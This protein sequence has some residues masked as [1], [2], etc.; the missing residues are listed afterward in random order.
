MFSMI[1]ARITGR[2]CLVMA[3][4]MLL[5]SCSLLDWF[6]PE[7]DKKKPV[8]VVKSWNYRDQWRVE[9]DR[10]PVANVSADNAMTLSGECSFSPELTRILDNQ[11]KG[12]LLPVMRAADDLTLYPDLGASAK[13][14][15]VLDDHW[16]L[17][18]VGDS[19]QLYQSLL[20]SIEH[21]CPENMTREI[22]SCSFK[23]W[24]S[25]ASFGG[26]DSIYD[27][28]R[29]ERWFKSHKSVRYLVMGS[30]G[31]FTSKAMQS[32]R[33]SENSRVISEQ[34]DKKK[35]KYLRPYAGQV[36]YDWVAPGK[37]DDQLFKSLGY[38]QV[39]WAELDQKRRREGPGWLDTNSLYSVNK[40]LTPYFIE[41]LDKAAAQLPM[42][43]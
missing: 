41:F 43:K 35:S 6:R 37:S 1:S 7:P 40:A 14:Y 13:L 15:K 16:A 20:S 34:S 4:S 36:R 5:S 30:S 3:V 12:V 8:P 22:D 18:N 33:Y 38:C 19:L 28:S 32:A 42:K 9:V 17:A 26:S 25:F 31:L 23:K 2:L 39:S 24:V 11:S 21:A 29:L 27:E 10:L